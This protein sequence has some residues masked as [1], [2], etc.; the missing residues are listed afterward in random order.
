MLVNGLPD[1]AAYLAA[2]HHGKVRLSI[3]SLPNETK[4]PDPNIRFARG[5]WDGDVLPGIHLGDGHNLN[6]TLLDLSLMELGESPRGP[7]WL[8]RMLALRDDPELGPFRLSFL[9]ALLRTADWRAS[10]K[11]GQNAE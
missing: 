10:R 5:I 9:E 1:L 11:S 7:S 3:R 4:P 8:S 6:D 2:A